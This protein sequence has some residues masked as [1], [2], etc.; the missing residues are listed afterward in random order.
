M[1]K[2]KLLFA[3]K[4]VLNFVGLTIVV[5]KLTLKI[6]P[7]ENFLLQWNLH[8]TDTIGTLPNCPYYRGVLSSEVGHSF[9]SHTHQLARLTFIIETTQTSKRRPKEG[10]TGC[11]I[12]ISGILVS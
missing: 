4:D 6:R 3:C 5:C 2:I 12:S 1:H 7:I 8:N 10:L 9:E 11:D